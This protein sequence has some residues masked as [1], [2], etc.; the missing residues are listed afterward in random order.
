MKEL[1]RLKLLLGS[2]S[3]R[4]KQLLE[5]L[6]LNF[7][8]EKSNA[9]EI[10]PPG[11]MREE[12]AI[13]LAEE[14]ANVLVSRLK[15]DEILI[16]ADTIVWLNHAM[17]GK[18]ADHSEAIE[19][20][21]KLNG[22]TH[23]VYTAICL[24]QYENRKT[25]SVSSQVTFRQCT[26]NEISAYVD[27]YHPYDKA[28]AYGAQECLPL[29][30]DPCSKEEK[31]FLN[32]IGRSDLVEKTLSQ[33]GKKIIPFISNIEGSYFNVMGLPVVELVSELYSISDQQK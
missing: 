25:I 26:D 14:K 2:G 5:E 11:L 10:H 12:I 18:P 13:R 30:T 33:N 4:R 32:S 1:T 21:R 16:T 15:G 20:L 27:F 24:Q 6:G 9:D 29:G 28:G 23:Q 8:I 19:M 22:N 31:D 7:R 17:L 3:P